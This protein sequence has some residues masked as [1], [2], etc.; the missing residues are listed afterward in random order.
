MKNKMFTILT[1]N[2]IVTAIFIGMIAGS[3]QG[4]ATKV[5]SP[6]RR[7]H[8]MTAPIPEPAS[9]AVVLLAGV[10]VLRRRRRSFIDTHLVQ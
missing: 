4:A 9:L 8:A 3:A 5:T 6:D 7:E 1:S 2:C 10:M